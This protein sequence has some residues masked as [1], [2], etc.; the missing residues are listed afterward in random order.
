MPVEADDLDELLTAVRKTIKDNQQF[1]L[2]LVDE[3]IDVVVDTETGEDKI[4][5]EDGEE[6]EEL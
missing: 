4:E 5:V 1:L 6:F 2:G 3:T